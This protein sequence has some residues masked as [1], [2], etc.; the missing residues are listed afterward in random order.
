MVSRLLIRYANTNGVYLPLGLEAP[1]A[2]KSSD[3][4]GLLVGGGHLAS[5]RFLV[6]PLARARLRATEFDP[7]CPP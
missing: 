5:L 6:E 7:C 3:P 1:P 2:F 4:S